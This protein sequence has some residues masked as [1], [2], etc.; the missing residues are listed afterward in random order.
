VLPGLIDAHT[1]LLS[2]QSADD[3]SIVTEVATMSEADRALRGVSLAKQML[4]AGFTTVR[5]LGNVGR[6][7]DA[8][9]KRAIRKRIVEGPSMLVSTRALS[10]PGG[11]FPRIVPALQGLIDQEY[12]VVRGPEEARAAVMQAFY[13][14][15]DWIKVIVDHGPG[16]SLDEETLRAIVASAHR[17]ERKVAAHTLTEKS[18]AAAV[19]AGVH[20]IEHGYAITDATLAELAK[21]KIALVPTDYP[22][23]LYTRFAPHDDSR[24]M[25][26]DALKKQREGSNDRLRRA[27][28]AKVTIVSGSDAY[29]ETELADRG[30]EALLIFR[31]YAEAGMTSLEIVQAATVNAASLLAAGDWCGASP[32]GHASVRRCDAQRP[33]GRLERIRRREIAARRDARSVRALRGERRRGVLARGLGGGGAAL[34][35]LGRVCA[36]LARD[37]DTVIELRVR[38]AA[39]HAA[40]RDRDAAAEVVAEE[41]AVRFLDERSPL[42]AIGH[43][44]ALATREVRDLALQVRV[45]RGGVRG[46]VRDEVV[47][48]RRRARSRERLRRR[49]GSGR[50]VDRSG[51]RTRSSRVRIGIRIGIRRCVDGLLLHAAVRERGRDRPAGTLSTVD[52]G[53]RAAFVADH[54]DFLPGAARGGTRDNQPG[55]SCDARQ[56]EDPFRHDLKLLRCRNGGDS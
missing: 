56:C 20:S 31:A 35:E 17:N 9:L 32:S 39:R 24:Q 54:V 36:V 41:G 16:R 13:E 38:L 5:D 34:L 27:R 42:G 10:P 6:G 48:V 3:S 47:D 8:S 2:V 4:N 21:K 43:E 26:L 29:V 37:G 1:H 7:A 19:S 55:E 15:A 51:R 49:P 40:A 50:R 52:P 12:A 22:L 30:R 44:E 23:T 25:V 53:K 45:G 46:D 11:Q 18:A 28:K 33:G 14:G